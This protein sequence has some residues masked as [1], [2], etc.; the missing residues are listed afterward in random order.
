VPRH[1]PEHTAS[2]IPPAAELSTPAVSRTVCIFRASAAPR[3]SYNP[4]V[5]LHFVNRTS[6]HASGR[7]ARR[8]ERQRMK[9][10]NA[11]V[12]ASTAHA[13]R[14]RNALHPSLPPRFANCTSAH[15]S[16]LVHFP[17]PT[18]SQ[19]APVLVHRPRAS[20][21]SCPHFLPPTRFACN[22]YYPP[23]RTNTCTRNTDMRAFGLPCPPP[24]VFRIPCALPIPTVSQT[25]PAPMHLALPIPLVSPHSV[26]LT[27]F[28]FPLSN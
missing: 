3:I 28:A 26:P 7:Y 9:R 19:I 15:T 6:K 8:T 16:S 22:T 4:S 24:F 1:Y 27:R 17:S 12:R 14:L 11:G 23:L 10:Q 18:V 5:P 13:F 25:A 2:P 21:L 20:P